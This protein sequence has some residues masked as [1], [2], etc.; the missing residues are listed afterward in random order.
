VWKPRL[1][2]VYRLPKLRHGL[3]RSA[4]IKDNQGVAE[5]NPKATIAP[6]QTS[7]A[8][9]WGPAGLPQNAKKVVRAP[10]L[11]RP[12]HEEIIPNF[13]LDADQQSILACPASMRAF[14]S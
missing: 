1:D 12:L 13:V 7:L 2:N 5:T 4:Y 10:I 9:G 6:Q 14:Y 11:L 8:G 3:A